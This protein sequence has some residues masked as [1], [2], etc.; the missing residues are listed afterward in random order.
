MPACCAEKS[1]WPGKQSQQRPHLSPAQATAREPK[2]ASLSLHRFL[3]CVPTVHLFQPRTLTAER[4]KVELNISEQKQ[5][6]GFKNDSYLMMIMDASVRCDGPF[7]GI[8]RECVVFFAEASKMYV[9]VFF[10]FLILCVFPFVL[11]LWPQMDQ[12]DPNHVKT[13]M[14]RVQGHLSD[15][16][17]STVR[18]TCT[19]IKSC[20]PSREKL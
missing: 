17:A 2:H 9:C 4:L 19:D 1:D 16:S 15:T 18:N 13:R 6:N 5:Y 14:T 20:H 12:V 7:A 11:F 10:F 3:Q 8:S